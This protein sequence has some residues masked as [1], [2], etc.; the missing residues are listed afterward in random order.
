[1]LEAGNGRWDRIEEIVDAVLKLAPS[2]RADYLNNACAGDAELRREV[3]SLVAAHERTGVVDHIVR[4]L[5][6][7]AAR[8]RESTAAT[9]SGLQGRRVGQY[10]VLERVG[11]GGMGVVHKALDTRLDRTVALKFLQ[12]RFGG[13][14]SAAERFRLEA[15]AIAALEHPN[16][17][18]IHEIGETDDGQLFLAMP[19]YDGETLQ[20]RISTGTLPIGEAVGIAVQVARALS[21][22]HARGIIHRDIKPSNILITDDGVVK[23][24]DFGIAKLVDVTLTGAAGPLG[25]LAYMSPEQVRGEPVDHRTDLWSLGVVLYEMLT[26]RRPHAGETMVFANTQSA[27][28]P[29]AASHRPDVPPALERVVS[30]ALAVQVD[31]RYQSALELETA[32][33]GLGLATAIP[34]AVSTTPAERRPHRTS[35]LA[36]L[37]AAVLIPIVAGLWYAGSMRTNQVTGTT[38]TTVAV[39]PFADQSPAGDQEYFSDGITEELINSLGQL[40]GLRVASRTSSFAFKGRS[41]D[42]RTI[43]QQLGV[44]MVIEGSVRRERETLRITARLLNATDGYPLWSDTYNRNAGDAFAIQQEIARAIAQTLRMK[45]VGPVADSQAV[46]LP[47]AAA[48]DL[49]LKGR[50]ALYLKGRYAWYARTE[51]GV[52]E[53]VKYFQLAVDEDS[54]YVR[55]HAGLADAYAILGFYDYMPPREAFPTAEASARRAVA[56]SPVL[57]GPRAT[58]GYVALYHHWDLARGEEEFQRAIALDANYSTG[59]QWY[60]NLLTAAGRFPEAEREMRRAQVIDPLS[61]IAS[62][63]LGWVLYYAGNYPAAAAQCQRTLELNPEYGLAHLWR[64]W[65]LQEIADSIPAAVEAHRRAVV[66]SDSGALF[67]ASLARSLAL[68]GKRGESELLLRT[69]ESR[70]A[71]G[72]Y[73]PSYEIA[74]IHEALGRPD[75]AM[76]WLER[77]YEQRSHS[78]VFLKVDPQLAR[79]R[80]RPD[81]QRLVTQ[82]IPG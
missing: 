42:I 51:L 34:M 61:L 28:A 9:D 40:E 67:V 25:T 24:L 73:V 17:C 76:H 22:A 54:M 63:A 12:P 72:T 8:V 64:G 53:A 11:G 48:Y 74:K 13:D 16:I 20:Q 29:S 39:L 43:A 69:L 30:T 38:A 80:A 68:D 36:W 6:P 46:P 57:A 55:A 45:L 79:L 27:G 32:L 47:D 50:N 44:A 33:M 19:L 77:A 56:L 52:R 4:D 18:T 31:H 81:F 49:Y 66:E 1:M 26:G 37:A 60:A 65:A 5:A 59:H 2:A 23:L 3:D 82:V 71:R 41:E 21:K 78:M 10:Q 70:V 75:E 14:D 35:R 15:R 7:L 58:L 62:A